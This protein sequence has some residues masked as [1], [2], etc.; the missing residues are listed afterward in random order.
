M[1]D[2]FKTL[3]KKFYADPTIN[4]RTNKKVIYGKGPYE[5]LVK[6]F[7]IPDKKSKKS[8]KKSTKKSTK[9]ESQLIDNNAINES[10]KENMLPADVLYNV[11][12]QADIKT[13]NNLCITN[14]EASK[15][16]NSDRFWTDKFNN[17]NLP[18]FNVRNDKMSKFQIYDET[19]KA[20]KR[21]NDTLTIN[22]IECQ[23]PFNKTEGTIMLF[24]NGDYENVTD[25][26]ALPP[27]LINS[28]TSQFDN[29]NSDFH[30]NAIYLT[31]IDNNT[32]N[33]KCQVM[34][35]DTE[36]FYDAETK[37][38]VN[39]VKKIISQFLFD[40]Y[41]ELGY[42]EF[43]DMH[44]RPFI[45]EDEFK[46]GDYSGTGSLLFYIRRGIWETLNYY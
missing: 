7:G 29:P 42:M 1:E 15:Y 21:T 14:K 38:N 22:F 19:V 20:I 9:K 30:F 24:I 45:F 16:C 12:L 26:P 8:R 35:K 43:T 36:D 13:L 39:V 5:K 37:I 3:K 41:T 6:E 44:N 17:D 28:L 4:P 27:I 32:Y 10:F 23:R 33:I 25:I 11:L 40:T 2:D 46:I 34:D 31:Y 18:I